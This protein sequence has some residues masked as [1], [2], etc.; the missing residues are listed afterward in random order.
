[1]NSNAYQSLTVPSRA[2]QSSEDLQDVRVAIIARE[3]V[4][5]AIEAKHKLARRLSILLS[6]RVYDRCRPNVVVLGGRHGWLQ[7]R[8]MGMEPNMTYSA[9]RSLAQTADIPGTAKPVRSL[10]DRKLLNISA[11]G[12]G[13]LPSFYG[14]DNDVYSATNLCQSGRIDWTTLIISTTRTW[15]GTT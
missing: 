11:D 9:I 2:V 3:L 1:M 10:V 13:L 4:P 6:I 8:M 7:S 12:D 14:L 5:R 15:G